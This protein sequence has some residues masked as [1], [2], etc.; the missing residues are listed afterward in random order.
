MVGGG[1]WDGH[2]ECQ[3]IS[4]FYTT[5]QFSIKFLYEIRNYVRSYSTAVFL[6]LILSLSCPELK[7][8]L[9]LPSGCDCQSFRVTEVAWA[10]FTSDESNRE[11]ELCV[12]RR[13]VHGRIPCAIKAEIHAGNLLLIAFLPVLLRD[14]DCGW[15]RDVSLAHR[16]MPA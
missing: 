3:D 8:K 12:N 7:F 13:P 10:T 9:S 16:N 15:T 2:V 5:F 1:M 14:V 6:K 4:I 11:K